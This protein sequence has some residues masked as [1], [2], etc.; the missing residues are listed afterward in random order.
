VLIV[1]TKTTINA[2]LVEGSALKFVGTATAG[3]DHV[4]QACLADRSIRF[5]AASG[6]NANGVGE[7]FVAGLL[8]LAN[9][10][11]LTLAGMTVG[12]VGHG[13]VGKRVE[14]MARALGMKVLLNDPPLFA[15]TNDTKYKP[16]DEV[17]AGS[18]ILTLHV[19]LVEDGSHPTRGLIGSEELQRL[20]SGALLFNACRG[21]VLDG[22][23]VVAALQSG[24]LRDAV[25]DVWDPE[26][27]FPEHI[28]C[29]VAIGSAHIA[30]HS[31]E[32]KLNGTLQLY[33]ALCEVV[34]RKADADRFDRT[35][36][37]PLKTIQFE[38]QDSVEAGLQKIVR[39]VYEIREDDRLLRESFGMDEVARGKHFVRLR[40]SYRRR[41]EF[42][43]YNVS[44]CADE[45]MLKTLRGLGFQV[46][47]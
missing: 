3:V 24:H 27:H 28:Q 16:L 9:K 37:A 19:P 15:E 29:A 35:F 11:G 18:H 1:R 7:Y 46:V 14:A 45:T 10:H 31:F 8:E 30:G 17:I 23:A 41:D 32:G 33:R 40:R 42:P 36:N 2:A 6:C 39:Q 4:D 47:N 12:I 22:E 13:H 5:V 20:P 38:T 25:L 34:G 43:N 21:E 26:P 44:G